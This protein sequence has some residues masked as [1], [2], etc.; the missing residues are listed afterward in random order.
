MPPCRALFIGHSANVAGAEIAQVRFVTHLDRARWSPY[1]LLPAEGPLS[2]DYKAA[3]I[4]LVYAAYQMKT[5]DHWAAPS[6]RHEIAH[7]RRVIASLS[8]DVVVINTEVLPQAV[9]AAL[10]TPVPMMVH[11]HSF[12][13]QTQYGTINTE[14][15]RQAGEIW[16]PFPEVVT[17]CSPWV[18]QLYEQ[19]CHRPV[20]VIPNTTPVPASVTPYAQRFDGAP[21]V[22][23]L[24][25]VEPNKRPD[26]FIDAAARL[27]RRDPALDFE[28]H[29]YGDGDAGYIGLLRQRAHEQG[30]GSMFQF[31][32]RTV[33]TPAVY[34]GSAAVVVLS[35]MESFSMI[36]IEA[37][38]Y[39]CPV[40]ATRSG[41]PD[42]IIRHG[43]TGFLVEVGDADAVAG[44]LAALL[45]DRALAERMGQAAQRHFLAAFSP[46]VVIP[47]YEEALQQCMA[48]AAQNAERRRL[49]EPLARYFWHTHGTV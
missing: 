47:Q 7:I 44:S 16:L 25:A 41:G 46:A 23:M 2:L 14:S 19:M 35:E 42:G 1:V 31:H 9:I 24:G 37:A 11:I 34:N 40:I 26:L 20:T 3:G 10:C 38:S 32:P 21:R 27:H 8:P 33:N 28:C 49:V 45:Y 43:E 6:V 17:A 30:V 22:V 4:P 36:A 15:V 29:V 39:A 48:Q 13:D 12:I 5:V 18:A